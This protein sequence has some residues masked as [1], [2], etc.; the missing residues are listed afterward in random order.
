MADVNI[1]RLTTTLKWLF[2]LGVVRNINSYLS[3]W[4]GNNFSNQSRGWDWPKEIAV[5]TGGSSGFGLLFT[6]DLT[7]K[8][9]HVVILDINEPPAY[10]QSNP[11][12]SF[13]K[14][15][16]TSSD[17]VSS[18]SKRVQETVGHPSILINN[19]GIGQ[20]KPT[21]EASPAFIRKIF[22]VNTISHWYLI[23]AFLPDMLAKRKG[24]IITIASIAS[25]TA[26]AGIV[27]YAA[28]KAAAMALHEGLSAELRAVYKCPEIRTTSVHPGFADTPLV[29]AGKAELLRAGVEVMDPQLVSDA[30]VKQI[31]NKRGGQLIVTKTLQML[32]YFRAIPAWLRQLLLAKEERR[33]KVAELTGNVA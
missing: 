24:H 27:H 30:V 26:P 8:G 6:K 33:G 3:A 19:A 12:V 23:Q 4:A 7:A 32:P 14:C 11:K 17:E 5:V 16:V 31:L 18:V 28:T 21:L 20:S 29:H 2:A 25:F 13:F 15:D 1:G 22:E 9:I 10:I